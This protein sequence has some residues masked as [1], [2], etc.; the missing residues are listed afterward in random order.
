V[1]GF[2]QPGPAGGQGFLGVALGPRVA[3][4][5]GLAQLLLE[6]GNGRAQLGDGA[7]GPGQGLRVGPAPLG[8][9]GLAYRVLDPSQAALQVLAG[10]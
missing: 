5:P 10:G 2:L 6:L 9:L 4:V 7:L 1:L 3:P 8:F